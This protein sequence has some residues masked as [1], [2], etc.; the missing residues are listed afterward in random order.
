MFIVAIGFI[1]LN[2]HNVVNAIKCFNK[3]SRV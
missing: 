3:Y 1:R 2:G